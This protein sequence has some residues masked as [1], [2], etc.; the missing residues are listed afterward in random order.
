MNSKTLVRALFVS[1]TLVAGA[2]PAVAQ[3]FPG[4]GQPGC[5]QHGG[6]GQ[7][8]PMD[9]ARAAQH[10]QDRARRLATRLSLSATQQQQLQGIVQS[11]IQR[12]QQTVATQAP[13]TPERRAARMALMQDFDARLSAILSPAQRTQWEA[14]KLEMRARFEEHREHR[15]FG[16]GGF[17]RDGFGHGGRGNGQGRLRSDDERGI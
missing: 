13:R 5:A 16:R 14:I 2:A 4:G 8:G 11:E 9:P 3:Q 7:R 15:G 12:F 17:G 6:R 1:V 10:W